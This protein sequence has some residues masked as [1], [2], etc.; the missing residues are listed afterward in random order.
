[1]EQGPTAQ[2]HAGECE[3]RRYTGTDVAN[4]AATRTPRAGSGRIRS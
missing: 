3:A 1:M 2:E 4:V